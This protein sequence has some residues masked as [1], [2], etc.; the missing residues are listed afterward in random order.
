MGRPV[1]TPKS[2]LSP[3][4]APVLRA[5]TVELRKLE[6]FIAVAEELHF[7]RAAERLRIAQPGLSQ[8]IMALERSLGVQLFT[9][10][11]RGVELTEAGATFLEHARVVTE[12]ATRAV[13][14][15][16]LAPRPKSGFLRVGTHV[17]GSPPFVDELLSRFVSRYPE[18]QV[19]TRASLALQ[20]LE[21][22]A[23]RVVDVAIVPAP[24]PPMSDVRYLRLGEIEILAAVSSEHRLARLDRIPRRELLQERI[25]DWPRSVNPTLID[26]FR[27]SLFGETTPPGLV[28]ISEMT[29]SRLHY[30]AEGRGV[31]MVLASAVPDHVPDIVVRRIGDP[32][33]VMEMGLAWFDI[34]VSPFVLSFVDLAREASSSRN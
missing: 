25:F 29:D 17:L 11:S 19:E 1:H 10:D 18:V 5:N 31:T 16:R 3:S 32:V 30:V 8:Q 21:A 22:L 4:P 23:R 34:H 26:H 27:R 20:T 9:R 12:A 13:E 28:E 2:S 24:I 6:Y 33:P 14:S 7:G 15:I